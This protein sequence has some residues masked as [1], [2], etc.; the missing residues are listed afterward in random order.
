MSIF[1]RARDALFSAAPNPQGIRLTSPPTKAPGPPSSWTAKRQKRIA[2]LPYDNRRWMPSDVEAALSAANNSG[3]IGGPSGLAAI[4][5]WVKKNAICGGLMRTRCGV[6]RLP[7]EI[8]GS[9]Q[10]RRWIKGDGKNNGVRGIVANPKELRKLAIDRFCTGMG[11]GCFVWNAKLGYPEL[12]ALDVAGLRYLPG[13]D[14]WQY[15]GW[16]KVYDVTP[17]DGIWVLYTLAKDTPWRDGAWDTLAYEV[18]DAL[19]GSMARGTFIQAFSMPTILARSPQGASEH[20]KAEFTDSIIGGF[21]QI[22][23]VTNGF[24]LDFKQASAEG[25]DVFDATEKKLERWASVFICGTAGILDGGSGFS[26]SDMFAG[27]RGETIEE[28][29]EDLAEFENAQIWGPVCK[30]GVRAGHLEAGNDN[31]TINYIAKPPSKLKAEAEAVKAAAEAVKAMRDAGMTPADERIRVQ[32]QMPIEVVQ[33]PIETPPVSGVQPIQASEAREEDLPEQTY[34]EGIAEQL[35]A[36]SE[37][38]CP[39]P[40]HAD[41]HC[42]RC[43]VVRRHEVKDNQWAMSGTP[44]AGGLHDRP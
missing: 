6:A 43:G 8:N 17:G 18:I 42:P 20:Q 4:A 28:E 10:A 33:A 5:A 15:H 22:I 3:N 21:L 12:V 44:H 23:G 29:A 37:D 11:I 40:N 1:A 7:Y 30:W 34:S 27:V 24:E 19:Q 16:G 25:A 35:N 36:R 9:E 41:R 32:W 13:E 39:C 26:N 14:R 31:A 38:V 2:R